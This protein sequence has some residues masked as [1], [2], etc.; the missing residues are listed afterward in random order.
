MGG[1]IGVQHHQASTGARSGPSWQVPA[2]SCPPSCGASLSRLPAVEWSLARAGQK[3]PTLSAFAR[4]KPTRGAVLASRLVDTKLFIPGPRRS[5]A[6]P[7]LS[8]RLSHGSEARLTLISAPAGFGKTFTVAQAWAGSLRWSQSDNT[9]R[10]SGDHSGDEPAPLLHVTQHDAFYH[11]T[12]APDPRRSPRPP[13]CAER[14]EDC[15]RLPW[16]SASELPGR[17]NL[18]PVEFTPTQHL[19]QTAHPDSRNQRLAHYRGDIGRT[20]RW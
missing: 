13:S 5:V 9:G 4:R 3:W 19:I 6:R 7:R 11:R 18:R 10:I 8:G 17:P 2:R 15:R 16:S 14:G 1:S 12:A 20:R